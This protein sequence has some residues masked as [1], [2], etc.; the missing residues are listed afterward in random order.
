VHHL[1][2]SLRYGLGTPMLVAALA[3][4]VVL[5]ARSWKRALVLCSFPILFYLATG[6]GQTVFVR[7]IIPVV[8]FLCITAAVAV[9]E[10]CR[11]ISR[12]APMNLAACSTV[13]AALVALPS[14]ASVVQFDRLLAKP[15][16]RELA[17]VWIDARRQR[18][19]WLHEESGI[20][21]YPDFGRPQDLH[22]STFD[23][24]RRVFLS[25]EGQVVSPV[26]VVLGK[27]PLVGYTTPPPELLEVVQQQFARAAVFMPTTGDEPSDT[28]DQQDKFFL[29]YRDFSQRLRPG[30]EIYVYRR[31]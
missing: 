22:V 19:D 3:G 10:L 18:G 23:A 1:T 8:P 15:D 5:F 20:Q 24:G 30:P 16:S 27:S 29:P 21:I 6:Q 13:A 17:R 26:W 2:F 4:I 11:L 14:I 12:M 25:N 7:Y 31:R 28:F 9:V